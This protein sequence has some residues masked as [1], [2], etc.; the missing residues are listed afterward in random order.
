MSLDEIILV[1][2]L[3]ITIVYSIIQIRKTAKKFKKNN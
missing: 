2:I 3:A 1:G